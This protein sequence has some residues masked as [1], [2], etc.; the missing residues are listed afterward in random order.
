MK[1]SHGKEL[2]FIISLRKNCRKK[3]VKQK[4]DS[5]KISELQAYEKVFIM[6]KKVS[7][8]GAAPEGIPSEPAAHLC[9]RHPF[10]TWGASYVLY[11]YFI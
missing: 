4:R 6:F 11:L 10:G 3:C 9:Q 5:S 8:R 1:N 7:G 2:P